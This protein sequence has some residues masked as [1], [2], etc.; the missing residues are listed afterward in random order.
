MPAQQNPSDDV[1]ASQWQIS[2]SV[3]EGAVSARVFLGAPS[4]VPNTHLS[5]G[6]LLEN[7]FCGVGAAPGA[8]QGFC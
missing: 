2:L 3:P 8:A 4:Q 1:E 6:V 5:C 7:V